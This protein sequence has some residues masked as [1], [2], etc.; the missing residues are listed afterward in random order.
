MN[1]QFCPHCETQLDDATGICPACRWDPLEAPPPAA[2]EPERSLME[3]YRGTEYD[4]LSTM[5]PAMMAA[6]HRNGPTTRFKLLMVGGV[7]TLVGL[8]GGIL[9]WSQ[10]KADD[11]AVVP[12]SIG[13]VR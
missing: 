9:V 3:R 4:S 1:W 10:Y 11:E 13:R 6:R 7:L 2:V 5:A 12:A 8:Y